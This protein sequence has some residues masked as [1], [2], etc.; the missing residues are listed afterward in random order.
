MPRS[1]IALRGAVSLFSE[2]GASFH[3]LPAAEGLTP[4]LLMAAY[5]AGYQEMKIA[6]TNYGKTC[7]MMKIVW[8]KAFPMHILRWS[9]WL[10]F[11]CSSP[12]LSDVHQAGGRPSVTFHHGALDPFLSAPVTCRQLGS[13]WFCPSLS[14]L[15]WKG[16]EGRALVVA[17]A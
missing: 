13:F 3:V 15:P 9:R 17:A 7:R 5:L 1:G 2:A 4:I 16:G 10:C 6:L 12:G 11:R 8:I 14:S